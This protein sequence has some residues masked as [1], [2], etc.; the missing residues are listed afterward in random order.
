[1]SSEHFKLPDGM[2]VLPLWLYRLC[3]NKRAGWL[4]DKNGMMNHV[5]VEIKKGAQCSSNYN[6]DR[7]GCSWYK[8]TR[9]KPSCSYA[10][11]I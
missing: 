5:R 8:R 11:E 9:S 4:D 1:M 2:Y 6:G 7:D 3:S 10:V